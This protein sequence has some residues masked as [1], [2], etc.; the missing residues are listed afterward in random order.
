MKHDHIFYKKFNLQ[1]RSSKTENIQAK[2]PIWIRFI[3]LK[4]MKME[5]KRLQDVSGAKCFVFVL[6]VLKMR[7]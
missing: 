1:K 6:S 7:D 2:D 4:I 3:L 5:P